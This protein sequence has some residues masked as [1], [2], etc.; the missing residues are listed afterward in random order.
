[1]EVR[2]SP[3]LRVVHRFIVTNS[4]PF[5]GDVLLGIDFL[6]R[7][8]F[9][10]NHTLSPSTSHLILNNEPLNVT[11]TDKP[12][13]GV[14]FVLGKS[15]FHTVAVKDLFSLSDSYV[16]SPQSGKFIN[17]TINRETQLD[18][19]VFIEGSINDVLV[20]RSLVKANRKVVRVWTINPSDKN[21]RL[22]AGRVLSKIEVLPEMGNLQ[23]DI[24]NINCADKNRSDSSIELPLDHLPLSQRQMLI[25]VL[26]SHEKL[27]KGEKSDIGVVPGIYHYIPTGDATPIV[28]RQW[29]LP[30]TAKETI[31]EQCQNMVK[32]KV[33][34]PSTS[35]WMSPIVLVRKKTTVTAS[36]LILDS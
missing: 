25:S 11:F 18:C 34:E 28:A 5:P 30:Q 36:A 17:A 10:F 23:V 3:K 33:I 20:P 4:C 35:P 7:F 8:E 27:F 1:M 24:T 29:R 2:I 31:K 12:S 26:S 14:A 9:N 22:R 6:R 13:L 15:T 21:V 19:E 32:S 16:I